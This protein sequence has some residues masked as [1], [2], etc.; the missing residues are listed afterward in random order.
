[1]FRGESRIGLQKAV[2]FNGCRSYEDL[3]FKSMLSVQSCS[4]NT[5]ATK[6]PRQ[7]TALPLDCL[8]DG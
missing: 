6:F 1:M 4:T 2:S 7:I 5:A 3:C 8:A